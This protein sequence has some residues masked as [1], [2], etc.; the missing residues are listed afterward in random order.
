MS[1]VTIEVL[2]TAAIQSRTWDEIWEL[3]REF[4]DTQRSYAEGKLQQQR[5]T[6]LFRTRCDRTLVGMASVNVAPIVHRGRK[7]VVI[8]TSHVLLRER[9]RGLNLL[10]QSGFRAFLRARLRFPLRPIYWFFDTFSYKSYLLL[11]RNFRDFWPRHDQPTPDSERALIN[12]L[13]AH[14]YGR[15]WR[16]GQGIVER[17]GHKKLRARTAPLEHGDSADLSLAFFARA[18]PG[19]AEGDMLVC[20]CPLSLPNW[21]SLGVRAIRRARRR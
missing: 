2:P 18:N 20:L 14:Y 7:L 15:D 5:E 10:Q 17:S 11:P 16:P 19:H 21:I 3:T 12:E 1:D 6:V 8:H 13:A 9:Y 4:Y